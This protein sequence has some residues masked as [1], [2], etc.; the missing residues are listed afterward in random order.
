MK[1]SILALAM[2]GLLVPVA[3]ASEHQIFGK[4]HA[5]VENED[6]GANNTLEVVSHD[7]RV[8]IKGSEDL[9]DGLAA[10]YHLEWGVDITD[11]DGVHTSVDIDEEG[12]ASASNSVH[13]KSRNQFVGLKG[14]FGTALFGR[15]DTPL[16]MSQGKFDLFGDQ[17]G[18]IKKTFAGELRA[19]DVMAYVT[20]GMGGFTG[21]VALVPTEDE[22]NEL[23]TS[24][25]AMYNAD[26]FYFGLGYDDYAENGGTLLRAT[27][28]FKVGPAGFGLMWSTAEPDEGDSADAYAV[29]AFF[30]VGDG[31][32][33]VQYQD[34]EG[35]AVGKS[36]GY[37][38]NAT[39]T[40]V[41][42]SHYL[43]KKTEVYGA[44]HV[45]SFDSDKE[46]INLFG[47]GLIHKFGIKLG[48]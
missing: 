16:K 33:K 42:Y 12:E 18:D 31:K 32:F 27:A 39:V 34:G 36:A 46:D 17:F 40:S 48:Q 15:H 7:S 30:K 45:A 21:V 29:N 22:A 25:A 4:L 13:W 5:A 44:Y 20:P 41:G 37:K 3:H 47:L 2:A 9:T 14:G 43:S 24:V 19:N 38:E 26:S 1:K 8:G 11:E 23:T 28:T 6:D 10:I 35:Q